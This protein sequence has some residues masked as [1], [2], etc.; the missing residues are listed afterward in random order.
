MASSHRV[1]GFALAASVFALSACAPVHVKTYVPNGA[2]VTVYRT[3]IWAADDQLITGDPRLDDNRFFLEPLRAEVE[4]RLSLKGFTKVVGDTPDL[5][6]HYHATVAQEVAAPGR[7]VVDGHYSNGA[8]RVYETCE[9]LLDFVDAKT[10]ELVWRGWAEAPIG[11]FVDD[12]D[13]MEQ[14][15]DETVGRILKQLPST[16][17]TKI[18]A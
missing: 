18:G 17:W 15:I 5:V 9:L 11:G 1:I 2:N 14:Q 12:Q 6:L 13:R 10:E 16:F 7:D 8:A 4:K 3:Y